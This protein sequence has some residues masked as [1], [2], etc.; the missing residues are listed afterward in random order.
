MADRET[1]VAL[2]AEK[3]GEMPIG[4]ALAAKSVTVA[5][6]GETC[7]LVAARLA[8]HGLERVPVVTDRDSMKLAGIVSR[9]DLVK[10]SRM[11]FEEEQKKERFRR[12]TWRPAKRRG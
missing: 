12:V 5:L 9:S 10:P 8:V 4:D 3:G 6:P 11:H 1:L 2:A 7:R